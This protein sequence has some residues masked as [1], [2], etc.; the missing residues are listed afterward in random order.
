LATKNR[1]KLLTAT[2]GLQR[3]STLIIDRIIDELEGSN[4][5]HF[6]LF[7]PEGTPQGFS[8]IA[9]PCYNPDK[10]EERP[11]TVT[12]LDTYISFIDPTDLSEQPQ[13]SPR[14][15]LSAEDV[16]SSLL[17][18]CTTSCNVASDI[19]VDFTTFGV[20]HPHAHLL[21]S[22]QHLS[23]RFAT[24]VD[25][26]STTS[27]ETTISVFSELCF[28]LQRLLRLPAADAV[29]ESCRFAAAIQLISPLWG[30]YPD[31]TLVVNALLHKLTVSLK[32]L[33]SF[34]S[35]AAAS[36]AVPTSS[37]SP[38]SGLDPPVATGP[39]IDV[40]YLLLW[41]LSVGAAEADRRM[42]EHDWFVGHLVVILSEV[43]IEE[44]EG[45]GG[46]RSVL[47]RF[48]WHDIFCEGPLREVWEEARE[49]REVLRVME[50]EMG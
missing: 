11:H 50:R 46:M 45:P 2:Y 38:F 43:G 34:N 32:S 23:Q 4:F 19:H 25:Y 27:S 29:S 42:P 1:K 22:I 9:L 6:G 33:L 12:P 30:Y 14:P 24:I 28:L 8:D 36:T 35:P 21:H 41:L 10:P 16:H 44:W 7:T 3:D 48:V 31:C 26:N 49:R 13:V 47:V 20:C 18:A 37:A 17:P 15:H 5:F 39:G 40:N